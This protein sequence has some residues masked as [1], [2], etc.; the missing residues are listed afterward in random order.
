MLPCSEINDGVMT[1][2]EELGTSDVKLQKGKWEVKEAGIKKQ[3]DKKTR[4][5][6][7]KGYGNILI[8]EQAQVSCFG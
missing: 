3:K 5:K 7:F 4:S 1:L 8:L 2:G 6:D